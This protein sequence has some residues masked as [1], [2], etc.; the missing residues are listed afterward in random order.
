MKER[1]DVTGMTCS[2][3]SSHVEKS[4]GKLTGVENVSVNLLTNSMQVEFDENKLDTAGIIKAVED[5]GYG[6]AVKDEHAKSGK[7][8][9]GQSDSQEN[10]G[11]SAVEQNVKNMKKRLIVSLI[12][13]IPLMYVSMGHMIYQWLNI[14]MPPFTMNFLHGNENAITY[15]FTQ[16]LLLLPILIANQKYFKN[17]FKTL[18]HRSPNMDSLIAIGAGAAILYGIFAI[19]RIGYAMGHGD[20]MVVHQ[21]AHD[22]YFES[23]G[24]ILTLITIGKYLETKSKGKT[25]EAI[26]K[27]LNLAPKTV[28]VV[29]DGVEQVVDAADV[30]K[31]EIFLVKPGESV[32]VDGI[33]LEGK[34]SFDESAITGESIP[35]PKQEGD[36]IVSASMNKSGLIRA[37]ATKVGEDTTIAQIIRLVEEASSSKAPIAKMADKIAGVFVPTVITIALIAG[38]IWLISGATFEFAMSTAIAVL[39]ISCPCALGLATPVAIMVGTGKGAE[40]GILI[41]SGD[42]LETAHQIDTVVLDKTGTITQGKPVVTD[43][44]CAAGKNADKTQLLQIAGS[45]EKGSEHPLAEAIVNYCVTNNISLEKVTDFNAL[46]GKGIEG[47]VSGTHYY[48]GNEKMMEEKG[49]SLSTEQKNQIQALAKQG[50]TPL[51]FADEKQFLGIVAVADVVKPTSKEAVQKFRDYGIHVIMLTGDNEVTAQAIKEQVGIDE[52][53]A[54]VLPTQ[55]EKK[56]SAL[57]QAG[58]KVAM[59]GDGVNDAPALASA[60]VGIAIGAGTDVAIESADIVLMKNDLLDAVGAVKLSKAVIRNIKENLFWAFFY[61]S[62]GIPLAAGVLYPL[63]QIKLNPMFGAAAM[64]LSSVC[65]VSNALRLRW[66]KLHDAKKTQSEPHQDVAASTIADINQHNALDNNIKSTNNDK[67]ESTMTTTISIEGMMCAHCQAHVEKALKEVAGVTEV[68]VSLENKNAV[69]TG[70]ASVEALKQAVVDAG[71]EVTDVK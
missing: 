26:T 40:N 34:S 60:D 59:I 10:S 52:V 35:V 16:F 53:I 51:L 46:F 18:W 33:V 29:R 38:V 71:Y 55:K 24:T 30:E 25:S 63:F 20:M 4:V 45:L 1:F 21:Y 9:S 37:K 6:A 67:G 58:H 48:A 54:G 62:I 31:G 3:C 49:I 56:I 7:K 15:A 42:A 70:D 11:L 47:T 14:P 36:T 66:V 41:K 68:T 64:S 50:R 44:I 13:W 61:N 12:F 22:L 2:A 39:V 19:Y 57:K 69:V 23:A 28:T 8:T 17:G 5:A 65:V 43:I 27:L 32:A